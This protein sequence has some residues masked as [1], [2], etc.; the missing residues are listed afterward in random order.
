M[1]SS[2]RLD[3]IRIR[4]Y[5]IWEREGRKEGRAEEYWYRAEKEIDEECR[6]AIAGEAPN[7][8]LPLPLI[9][10]RPVRTTADAAHGEPERSQAA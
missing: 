10:R 5:V 8:V 6:A 3:L 7:V 4:S 1:Y 2:R 9:S